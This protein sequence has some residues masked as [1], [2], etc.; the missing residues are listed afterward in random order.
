MTTQAGS[1]VGCI[2]YDHEEFKTG[3]GPQGR[4]YATRQEQGYRRAA[5]NNDTGQ[6]QDHRCNARDDDTGQGQ[7]SRRAGQGRRRAGQGRRRVAACGCEGV[8]SNAVAAGGDVAN[9]AG[10]DAG[11]GACAGVAA[12]GDTAN[13]ASV[14]PALAGILASAAQAASVRCPLQ[15]P[16]CRPCR[17]WPAGSG[18]ANLP[19]KPLIYARSNRSAVQRP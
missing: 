3:Q 14:P 10:T 17:S 11:T 13:S 5:R 15:N 16:L 2:V 9:G 1:A 4:H 19:H 8:T 6:G 7:G 18:R 12:V